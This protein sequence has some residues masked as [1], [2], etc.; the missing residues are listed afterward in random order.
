MTLMPMLAAVSIGGLI[1]L[2]IYVV[3]IGLLMW[4]ALWI[5]G[6]L[7]LPE[8]FGRIATI[9][10]YVIAVLVVILLLLQLVQ[11]GTGLPVIVAP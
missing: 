7:P 5:I 10:V 11:G 3:I 2:L 1:N 4:L 9:I 8:P 6:Q